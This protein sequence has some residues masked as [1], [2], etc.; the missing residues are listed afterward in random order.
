MQLNNWQPAPNTGVIFLPQQDGQGDT[1]TATKNNISTAS[2]HPQ[3]QHWQWL[4]QVHSN[5]VCSIKADSIKTG[6]AEAGSTETRSIE[7]GS[8]KASDTKLAAELPAADGLHT[9]DPG[10]ALC[11]LSADCLPILLAAINQDTGEATEIGIVH[12]GWRGLASGVIENCLTRFRAAPDTITAM[13]GPAIGPCHFEVGE[14]VLAAFQQQTPEYMLQSCFKPGT[15]SGK[16][17]ADLHGLSRWRLHQA[18]VIYIDSDER[19]TYCNKD[20]N[21]ARNNDQ[22]LSYR[23]DPH[24]G[25]MLSAIYLRP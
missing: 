18:G 8:I 3:V 15:K 17:L 24:C 20:R 7:T 1:N 19:C 9:A 12:A 21:N 25:R 23:R 6:G 5:K 11:I 13:L 2:D 10:L 4:N 22:L 16:Y 14:D